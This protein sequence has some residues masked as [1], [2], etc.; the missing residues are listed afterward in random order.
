MEAINRVYGS[1]L[2]TSSSNPASGIPPAPPPTRS[3]RFQPP[4]DQS[5]NPIGQTSFSTAMALRY[6]RPRYQL[7][8]QQEQGLWFTWRIRKWAAQVLPWPE[9]ELEMGIALDNSDKGYGFETDGTWFFND[10]SCCVFSCFGI[11]S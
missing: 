7:T 2:I 6:K 8:Q 4:A 1:T 11:M 10:V 3:P 9:C 5:S